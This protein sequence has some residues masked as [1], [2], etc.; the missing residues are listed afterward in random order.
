[1]SQFTPSFPLAGKSTM[2]SAIAIATHARDA[3][4]TA[5]ILTGDAYG[6][7][8]RPW[9]EVIVR[10][11]E[12]SGEDLCSAVLSLLKALITD[13][14]LDTGSRLWLMAAFA[15][16]AIARGDDTLEALPG[17]SPQRAK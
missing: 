1:M 4:R 11:E 14:K 2:A 13:G 6:E 5:Q 16:E 3:R 7:K 9:R 17:G 10:Q 12:T 15:E 8:V